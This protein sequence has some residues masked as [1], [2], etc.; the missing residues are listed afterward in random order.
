MDLT[1]PGNTYWVVESLLCSLI[2]ICKVFPTSLDAQLVIDL[3][4]LSPISVVQLS[5]KSRVPGTYHSSQ[6]T[7]AAK[8]VVGNIVRIEYSLYH[9]MP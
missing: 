7:L 9:P 4:F 1:R 6:L 2:W 3:G 8:M 5:T